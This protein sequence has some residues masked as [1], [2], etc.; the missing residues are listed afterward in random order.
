MLISLDCG[1]HVTMYTYIKTSHC[2][3]G[4]YSI[5]CQFSSV[6]LKKERM[7]KISLQKRR[8]SISHDGIGEKQCLDVAV[9]CQLN[10]F[11]KQI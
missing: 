5:F 11:N 2:K 10:Q 7:P 1:N 9:F 6:K 3:P 4:I 8:E